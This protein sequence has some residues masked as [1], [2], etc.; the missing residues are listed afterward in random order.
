[1]R[2][3]A[4]A[5]DAVRDMNQARPDSLPANDNAFGLRGK[6]VLLV[7]DEF[8]LILQLEE[9]LHSLGCAIVG[10]YGD[11]HAALAGAR[12]AEIDFAILDVNL[13]GTMVFPLAD[14]LHERGIP[15]I[16]LTGYGRTSLPERFQ[17]TPRLSK[18]YD[19]ATLLREIKLIGQGTASER[20]G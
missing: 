7:D 10:P 6:R 15:F 13:N 19:P 3:D 16:L 20:N 4:R 5:R 8:L 11:L 17:A 14:E 18:P 1:M 12:R 2:S 9:L